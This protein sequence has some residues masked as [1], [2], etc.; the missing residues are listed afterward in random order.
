MTHARPLISVSFLAKISL[1]LFLCGSLNGCVAFFYPKK[2]K[3]TF[4]TGNKDATVYID[5][6]EA[7][8]GRVVTEKVVKGGALQIVVKAPGYKDSYTAIVQTH[9]APGFW[10]CI[11]F[12]L[13]PGCGYPLYID[14][15]LPKGLSYDKEI[16][17]KSED[18]LVNRNPGDK[19]IDIS[20]IRLDLKD[21]KN[22]KS[23]SVAYSSTTL[24]K[25]IDVAEKKKDFKDNK[26]DAKQAKKKKG[27]KSLVDEADVNDLTY[28]DTKFSANVYKTLKATGFVDTVNRVFAD[29]N[30]TLVLEGSIRKV[31]IYTIIGKKMRGSYFKSKIFLRWYIKNTYNEIIDSLDTKE[32]SGDFVIHGGDKDDHL[33]E[34]MYGDAVDISYLRLHKDGKLAKYLKTESNFAC[35]DP[36]LSLNA[37][38]APVKERGDASIPSV[39]V[40]TKDGHG[41]G[42]AITEDGYIITNYHVVA[43]KVSGKLNSIK[44]ITSSGEEL[45]GTVVRYNKYRDLAL[46]KVDKKFEK[47]FKVSNVKSFK[48][49]MDVYTIGAPKSVELGQSFSAG[50]LSNER[51]ANNNNLLQLG[52][53]VNGGNSG[54]PLFDT[55]GNLHGVIVSK[56]IGA[57]TEGVSFAIPGYLIGEYLNI[58]YQ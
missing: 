10:I 28:D 35:T 13:F 44:V 54:G 19:Y 14:P 22:I 30:N 32:Y 58:Q 24:L 4:N 26:A 55:N 48:N 18:K 46:I 3:M 38:R 40:K 25:D 34:K 21:K 51:K 9:R 37:V 2:Q 8:K 56:L 31:Y 5:K 29:N 52:M 33:W 47:A 12:D 7:G 11:L 36:M 57:N 6:E 50:V 39:I 45:A 1:V 49:L 53:S 20:N 42:F 16:N 23:Y 27:K 17:L 15:W 41:S 43:G